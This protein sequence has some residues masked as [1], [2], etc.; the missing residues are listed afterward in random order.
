MV[1][2]LDATTVPLL[3]L[4]CGGTTAEELD[5]GVVPPPIKSS[6]CVTPLFT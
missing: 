5:A 4:D 1:E 6:T 2:E 3:E